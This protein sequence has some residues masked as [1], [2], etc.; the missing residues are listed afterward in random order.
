MSFQHEGP[1]V[2]LVEGDTDGHVVAALAQHFEV[3]ENFELLACGGAKEALRRFNGLVLKAGQECVGLLIDANSD[4]AARWRAVVDRLKN[5]DYELPGQP[6]REGLIIDSPSG[7]YPRLGVWLMPNNQVPGMLEDFCLELVEADKKSVA[8][9][10]VD[11]AGERGVST[12]KA[13]HRSKAV[14]HTYLAWQDEPGKPLG[15][16]ITAQA[17]RPDQPLAKSFAGWLER[18]FS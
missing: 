5:Y 13:A 10:A 15:Q 1:R 2:L 16:S 17:L 8:E 4:L 7:R 14:V 12:F 6:A 18:L 9:E 3:P 11:L